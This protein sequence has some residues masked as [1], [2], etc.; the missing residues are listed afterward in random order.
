M[1]TSF[2]SNDMTYSAAIFPTLDAD[3]ESHRQIQGENGG[4]GLLRVDGA[5]AHPKRPRGSTLSEDGDER[6]EPVE[7]ELEAA[8]IAKLRS[9]G[10]FSSWSLADI[11]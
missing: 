5:S 2:L 7:D 4:I 3:L 9:A 10:F 1:F 8:Q 11:W 6:S